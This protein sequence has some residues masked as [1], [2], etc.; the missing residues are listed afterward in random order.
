MQ[1][2]LWFF[3]ALGAAVLW[4]LQYATVEQLLK[5]IPAPWLT[6]GHSIALGLVYLVLL[7]WL[8][9][10]LNP[11]QFKLFLTTRNLLLFGLVVLIS[12]VST[13]LIFSA[14]AQE[15]ATKAS[16]IEI[17]YPLFVAL[18]AAFLY[19]EAALSWHTLFGGLLI[20]AGTIVVLQR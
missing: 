19:R 3:Y 7:A 4:G 13:L 6:L 2:H 9:P 16:L 5:T 1:Q 15:T 12:C 20:L 17:S 11:Q 14:I 18:F 10:H 8:H